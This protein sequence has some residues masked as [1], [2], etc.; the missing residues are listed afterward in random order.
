MFVV[1]MNT[2]GVAL[3]AVRT[4]DPDFPLQRSP[5][6]NVF[7]TKNHSLQYENLYELQL[8]CIILLQASRL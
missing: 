6:N 5:K 3:I 7:H 4:P 8:N 1:E 2:L